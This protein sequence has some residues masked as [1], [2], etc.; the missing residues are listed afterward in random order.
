MKDKMNP[1]RTT[2]H[3]VSYDN[4]SMETHTPQ[5][6]ECPI[7]EDISYSPS[8]DKL[9]N[10]KRKIQDWLTSHS[11]HL[12][13]RSMTDDDYLAKLID[14]VLTFVVMST[15]NI[16]GL[17]VIETILQAFRV[18]IKCRFHE[19]TW[20]TLSS[21]FYVYIKKILGDFTVQSSESF[22]EG[23][24]GYLNSYKNICN[25]EIA[26][27][28]YRCSMYVL[29]LSIF[30]KLGFS[31]DSFGYTKLE[32]V[33][34]KKK[35]YKKSDF[36]HV[37]ADT[38]LFL[39]ERGHQI[40]LTGDIKCIFHSGGS[41]K[42]IYDTCRELQRKSHL[43]HNPEEY[44]FTE[45]EF[46]SE[47]DSII[48]KLD[49]VSRHSLRLDKSDR[50]TVKFTLSDMLMLRD[51][52]NTK[53][54]ARRNRKA[55]FAVQIFGDSG[56]GK[57][58]LTN[59]ICTYFAKHENLPLGD[60]F[61]YTVNPAAKYWDGFVSSCHTIILD[62]VANEAPEMKDPKSLNQII[63]IINNASY[64][65]DQASLEN[66]GKT[67]LRAKLVVGTTNVKNL[68]AYHYF[69]CPSAV[70]RRFPYIITPTVKPEYKDERGMLSSANV[71]PGP[72][73]DLWTFN[74]DMV[75]PVAVSGGRRL[76]EFE[77]IHQNI[78]LRELLVWLNK[79]ISNFNVDQTRVQDCIHQM[80][81]VNL[82]L[83]CN[84]PDTMCA[85]TVQSSVSDYF[86]YIIMMFFFNIIWS[87]YIVQLMRI[88]FYY[89]VLRS[90]CKRKLN[91]YLFELRRKSTTGADWSRIGSS[92]QKSICSPK[93]L[94]SV[95]AITV[96]AYAMYKIYKKSTPQGKETN[97][98]GERPIDE[99][100]GREN[101]WYNN[102]FDLCAADFTRES[103]S[104]KGVEFSSFCK[105]ISNNVIVMKINKTN[106]AGFVEG[107]ALCL[108]GHIY[109]TNNHNV[110]V[111]SEPTYI[112]IIQSCSLGVNSNLKCVISESDIHRIPSK[113]IAFVILRNLPP[114]KKIVKYF[115]AGK[116]NGIFDGAY[117]TKDRLG[118]FSFV[119]VVSIRRT[120][121]RN[122]NFKEKNIDAKVNMWMGQLRSMKTKDGDC[123]SPLI[124]NSSYGYSIVG[125]HCL[126]GNYDSSVLS[127]EVDG[128]FIREIYDNLKDFNVQSGD[129]SGISSLSAKR[130]VGDLH[131][132]SV[133]RYIEDGSINVYGSFTD[134]R[135][136]SKSYVEPSPMSK[137]L[138]DAGY[139]IK[140]CKPEMRSWVPWHIAAKD[141]VRPIAELDTGILNKCVEGYIED[142][143]NNIDDVNHISNMLMIL[144]DFTT[145]NGAQV[146]Y[147]DKMK[148]NTSAGNPWKKSKKYFLKSIPPAYGMQDPVELDDEI[149][150]RMDDIL[151]CY[152]ENRQ[153]HPNFCAHLKDEP[154]S[155]KKAKIG[156]TRVF[157]GATM[158]WS[159]IVRKYL[160]SFARLLQNERFAFE[161][162][163]G[164]IAQSLEWHELYYYIVKNGEDRIVAGDYKA[165]DKRMSPK[166]ILAAFD[167]IIYFCRSSGN[168][169]E[170]DI[171]IIRCI[172]EDTAFPL[173]DYNGDLVQ[174]FGSNP[175]GNPLTVI[176]NSIVN[177]LR[178]RYVYYMIN[179]SHN[180]KTFKQDVSLMTYGDDNI[181]SVSRGCNW[182][183]HSAIA[184][185]FAKLNI[186]YTMADKE[187][188]SVPFIHINDASFLKRRWRYDERLGCFLAPLEDESI[189][190]SLMVW[191]RSKA[192]TKEAQGIDVISSA[193][194]EYFWYGEDVFNEK[195]K[196]LKDLVE[197]LNWEIW[198]QDSTFP[199]YNDLCADFIKR[200]KGCKSFSSVLNKDYC[201]Q[202]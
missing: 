101:V 164:T 58:T 201:T 51:D 63:Q 108:G 154:V 94:A 187:S 13:Y 162:A 86:P 133:F 36:L 198:I 159:L 188:A 45:S 69:S 44:G 177:S 91:M 109:I 41:Y 179:P 65:P 84:I 104:S 98:V 175:S 184:E 144:D 149:S 137:F 157:T 37:L 143:F 127:T 142:V 38:I 145:L 53:S 6:N 16:E 139:T 49:N 151:K 32:Q 132:K 153:F 117:A 61:R 79:A 2:L 75:R 181:M 161:A 106:V 71:P 27:K 170:E 150:E 155:F 180:V 50:D 70:Q 195:R 52:L 196:I 4:I 147:I 72:Y 148:R 178:M 7:S 172:A 90:Y 30:D 17:G 119:P 118:Q 83:C 97:L 183:N 103:A 194:R 89:Y 73:P 31:F 9:L 95:T 99:L 18:F 8:K 56:I 112:D 29:S 28:F 152:R 39:A 200:S 78:D 42:K 20:K 121:E 111:M 85:S 21:R 176:L 57:T 23:A 25:S 197:H 186:V 60:E 114:K 171:Q 5:C 131:K 12:F 1:I 11:M 115:Q 3:E 93:V 124:I 125:L 59:I 167:V 46:R 33:A 146:T 110:P 40:Y 82:C 163:P 165:F 87:S 113:D 54:A 189:E 80:R 174:L 105:K 77:T 100:D 76:A 26:V 102:S 141:L 68:N 169:T 120:N 192:V 199:T 48:E 160:L 10:I 191:T 129:L 43:L 173:V 24:R 66:K 81:S 126:A 122:L 193:L 19:S 62:D 64:C 55:P 67:P 35:F 14:D 88:Y 202:E 22:F 92:V 15:Q 128:A 130:E 182:F 166:E 156:K 116:A 140:Y 135:G 168:Y 34:L 96:A 123:G 47:L 185:T 107:R 74:V 134:F 136:K 158:D 138:L 190:K